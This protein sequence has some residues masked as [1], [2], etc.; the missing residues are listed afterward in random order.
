MHYVI[1]EGKKWGLLK[2]CGI[3]QKKQHIGK[4]EYFENPRKKQKKCVKL[5]TKWI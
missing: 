5:K 4:T 3:V 1:K 2:V